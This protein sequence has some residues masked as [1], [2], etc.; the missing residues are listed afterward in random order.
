MRHI[1]CM[2]TDAHHPSIHRDK[3]RVERTRLKRKK[4]MDLFYK[5]RN[6]CV[7][8]TRTLTRVNHVRVHTQRTCV[9]VFIQVMVA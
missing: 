2:T 5:Q 1:A 8:H 6:A 3:E 4:Q 9:Y 7:S